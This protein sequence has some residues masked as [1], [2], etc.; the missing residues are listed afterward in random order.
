MV[1]GG[2]LVIAF[3]RIRRLENEV[4]RIITELNKLEK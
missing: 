2:M 4:K 3:R 1:V